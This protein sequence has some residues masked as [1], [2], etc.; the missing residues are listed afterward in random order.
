MTNQEPIYI[1]PVVLHEERRG[2]LHRLATIEDLLK[3]PRSI[4]PKKLR[5]PWKIFLEAY[6]EVSLDDYPDDELD[7]LEVDKN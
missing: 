2:L 5:K 6:K 7:D 1:D 3:I 4:V